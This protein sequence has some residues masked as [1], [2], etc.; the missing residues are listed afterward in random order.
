MHGGFAPRM[1]GMHDTKSHTHRHM[2]KHRDPWQLQ[3]PSANTCRLI[4]T[5]T[6]A[7]VAAVLLPC[8]RHGMDGLDGVGVHGVGSE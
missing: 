7:S 6:Q 4:Q 1:H 2:C 8:G 5:D 3:H